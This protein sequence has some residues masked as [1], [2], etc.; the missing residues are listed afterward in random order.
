MF[1]RIEGSVIS[2]GRIRYDTVSGIRVSVSCE[3]LSHEREDRLNKKEVEDKLYQSKKEVNI[4]INK[5]NANIKYYKER[6]AY[7]KE[8]ITI[9]REQGNEQTDD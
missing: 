6:I 5:H 1:V 8:S 3:Y 2:G 9:L 4:D 7:A